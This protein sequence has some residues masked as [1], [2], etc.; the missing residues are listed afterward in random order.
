MKGHVCFNILCLHNQVAAFL[1]N[2]IMVFVFQFNKLYLPAKDRDGYQISDDP[3][4]S[5]N[6]LCNNVHVESNVV[7]NFHFFSR[8]SIAS[9]CVIGKGFIENGFI[10]NGVI[11]KDG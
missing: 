7:E 2:I 6:G 3:Y 10:E 1:L 5:Q 11:G 8:C 9:F 4:T